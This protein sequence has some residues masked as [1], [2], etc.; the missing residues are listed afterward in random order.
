MWECVQLRLPGKPYLAKCDMRLWDKSA[1][2]LSGER[3]ARSTRN[4]SF[5][6]SPAGRPGPSSCS[7]AWNFA[8]ASRGS[9]RCPLPP[10]ASSTP[11]G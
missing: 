1:E 11:G 2:N 4:P 9:T 10:Q 3:C 5:R 6:R 7:T 8:S